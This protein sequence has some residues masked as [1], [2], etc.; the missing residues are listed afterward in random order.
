MNTYE[1]KQALLQIDKARS[2]E[3]D[4]LSNKSHKWVR[5][6]HGMKLIKTI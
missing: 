5:T 4:K 2:L 1:R 3:K 6:Q